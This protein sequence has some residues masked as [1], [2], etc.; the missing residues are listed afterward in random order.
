MTMIVHLD[1]PAFQSG[2]RHLRCHD[3]SM[4]HVH[5]RWSISWS[6][7]CLVWRFDSEQCIVPLLCNFALLLLLL[8]LVVIIIMIFNPLCRA[9]PA[10]QRRV[11]QIQTQRTMMLVLCCDQTDPPTTRKWPEMY[12]IVKVRP[13]N[14]QIGQICQKTTHLPPN[15]WQ[16]TLSKGVV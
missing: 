7:S 4:I 10:S 2:N 9:S 15:S 12:Q 14:N 11:R 5:G 16:G 6:C 8:S 3:R 13:K 1:F